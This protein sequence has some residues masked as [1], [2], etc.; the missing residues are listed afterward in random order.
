MAKLRDAIS[1]RFSTFVTTGSAP[2]DP[3]RLNSRLRLYTVGPSMA[4]IEPMNEALCTLDSETYDALQFSVL[5][6]D[7]IEA[8]RYSLICTKCKGAGYYKRRG[9]D[10]RAPCFGARHINCDLARG[11]GGGWGDGAE[12]EQPEIRSDGAAIRIDLS[13]GGASGEAAAGA[14]PGQRTEGRG[15]RFGGEGGHR[16][17]EPTWRLRSILR[18]L[19]QSGLGES[20]QMVQPPSGRAMPARRYF[21][22]AEYAGALRHRD[23]LRGLWGTVLSV[24]HANDVY[25]LNTGDKT[26]ISFIVEAAVMADILQRFH[27]EDPEDVV[28]ADILVLDR[29]RMSQNG[30][31]YAK[32][33][34]ANYVTLRLAPP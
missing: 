9:I 5:P 19:V 3:S 17:R 34:S 24:R 14:A 2:A 26:Q 23:E 12:G 30:K 8:L 1:C 6:D 4:T 18:A 33:A 15:R 20:A 29:P 10:G 16:T 32:V 31:L 25:W 13:V 7:Q 21:V 22:H 28:G 11:G 27:V